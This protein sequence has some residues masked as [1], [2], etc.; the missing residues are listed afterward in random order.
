[1]PRARP[2]SA[3]LAAPITDCVSWSSNIF[4]G[5]SADAYGLKSPDN[6]GASSLAACIHILPKGLPGAEPCIGCPAGVGNP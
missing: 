6:P 2:R 4:G 1:M 3:K 5:G